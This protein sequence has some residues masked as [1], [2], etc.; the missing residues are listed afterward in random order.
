MILFTFEAYQAMAEALEKAT[1]LAPG[2][3]RA[4]RFENGELHIDIQ[5]P[6]ENED[7]FV[8]GSVAPPDAQLF[9]ALLL[10]HTLK[11]ER[12]RRVIAIF[13]YLA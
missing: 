2:R 9:S 1:G 5:T 12:A 8:L 3:F 10:A 6:V 13:P 4:T 11:K 7:C